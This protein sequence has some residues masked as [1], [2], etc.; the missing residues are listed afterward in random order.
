[1]KPANRSLSL[2]V[3]LVAC[4]L[5]ALSNDLVTG[6]FEKMKPYPGLETAAKTLL[7]SAPGGKIHGNRA[8]RIDVDVDESI[9][10]ARIHFEMPA[11]FEAHGHRTLHCDK[12][13]SGSWT[14]RA[15]I[16]SQISQIIPMG[17]KT[18]V[19]VRPGSKAG[20]A[21]GAKGD[22]RGESAK[23]TE[24]FTYRAKAIVK[25]KSQYVER[26]AYIIFEESK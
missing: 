11:D 1:M 13:D 19:V 24:V 25:V 4:A 18:V 10:L 3:I 7:E 6:A 14:C 16:E 9:G 2:L 22:Y 15:V 20:L 5:P 21:V 17:M 8:T 23:V 26:D 12:G